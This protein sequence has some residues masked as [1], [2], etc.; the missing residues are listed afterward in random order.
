M[1][2]Q[3]SER[4]LLLQYW[5]IS[6]YMPTF[7][8]GYCFILYSVVQYKML[9]FD[10]KQLVRQ[11]FSCSQSRAE[12][13]SV[14]WFL[15]ADYQEWKSTQIED[16]RILVST[17]RGAF[18]TGIDLC[19]DRWGTLCWG[20]RLLIVAPAVIFYSYFHILPA[21]RRVRVWLRRRRR[22]R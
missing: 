8:V 10:I 19:V 4:T 16:F 9:S 11:S 13:W 2:R 18:L 15:V 20:H 1:L 6:I 7:G 3:L 22:R 21:A 12:V 17:L 14:F 5:C